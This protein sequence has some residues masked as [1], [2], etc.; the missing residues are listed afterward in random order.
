MVQNK[1]NFLGKHRPLIRR[2]SWLVGTLLSLVF[3]TSCDS[4]ETNENAGKTDTGNQ[5]RPQI[6]EGLKLTHDKKFN[7]A[8][9]K[10]YELIHKNRNDAEAISIMSYIFL[11]SN[12][13]SKA[14]DMAERALKIDPFLFRPYIVLA[15]INFQVSGFDKA[16]DLS[17]QA[18]VINPEAFEAYQIIG[19]IYL[20]RG[21]TKAA[22]TV[23]KEAVRLDSENPKLLN[24]LASGYIKDK[25]YDQ[26]MSTLITLQEINSN[27]PGAHFNLAVVYAKMKDGHKAMRHITKAEKLYALEKNKIWLGKTRDIRRVIAKDFKFRPEDIN[28]GDL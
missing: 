1:D 24:F 25:Q 7:E 26:A 6:A 13:L 22:V 2:M 9:T 21:L 18:L 27:I 10:V 19:E 12:A 28:E 23:L 5:L 14:S 20:R 8:K 4:G 3:L 16:L 17:R 11:K 15:R